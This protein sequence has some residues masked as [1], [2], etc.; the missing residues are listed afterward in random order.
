M[1]IYY[2]YTVHM[3]PALSG[4]SVLEWFKCGNVIEMCSGIMFDFYPGLP[5]VLAGSVYT[6]MAY[7]YHL[8]YTQAPTTL[9]NTA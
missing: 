9:S 7:I 4:S 2:V 1:N 3:S 6:Q 8:C 5:H